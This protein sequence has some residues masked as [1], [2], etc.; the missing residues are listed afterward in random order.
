MKKSTTPTI[1]TLL[2]RGGGDGGGGTG[3]GT[4]GGGAVNGGGDGSGGGSLIR[5]LGVRLDISTSCD[6]QS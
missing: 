2:G 1:T 3:G 5:S 6:F 4:G